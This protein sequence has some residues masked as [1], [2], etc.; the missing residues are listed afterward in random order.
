MKDQTEQKTN[1]LKSKQVKK[2]LKI[3]DCDLAHLRQDG[4]LG[5]T[6]QGNAFLYNSNDVNKIKGNVKGS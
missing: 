1:W 6:K 2:E 5:F 3:S 4:F